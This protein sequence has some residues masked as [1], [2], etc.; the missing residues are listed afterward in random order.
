[1]STDLRITILGGRAVL[2]IHTLEDS[3][4][5]KPFL[6][7]YNGALHLFLSFKRLLLFSLLTLVF[8]VIGEQIELTR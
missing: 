7:I 2:K 4:F 5:S 6:D 1:M 3:V 8:L